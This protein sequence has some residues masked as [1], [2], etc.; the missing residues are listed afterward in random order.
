MA[1]RGPAFVGEKALIA[2]GA[3]LVVI[4]TAD[5]ATGG[6]EGGSCGG[7]GCTLCGGAKSGSGSWSHAKGLPCSGCGLACGG[8]RQ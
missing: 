3:L 2:S 7:L 5:F 6:G 4:P 8:S 1:T